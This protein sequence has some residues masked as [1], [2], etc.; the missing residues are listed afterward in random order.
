MAK[1]AQS[2]IH[3]ELGDK[4]VQEMNKSLP[5]LLGDQKIYWEETRERKPSWYFLK[6]KDLW[7][8]G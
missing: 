8:K 7:L 4:L 3:N 5:P 2:K 6:T 1:K